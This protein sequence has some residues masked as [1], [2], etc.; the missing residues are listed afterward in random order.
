MPKY[1]IFFLFSKK[2]FQKN[3]RKVIDHCHYTG[4][5]RGEANSICNLESNVPN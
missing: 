2:A 3:Y 4:Q 5:Y 1:A